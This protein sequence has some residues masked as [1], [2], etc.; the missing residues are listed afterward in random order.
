MLLEPGSEVPIAVVMV[1]LVGL[2][3]AALNL[4]VELEEWLVTVM[5]EVRSRLE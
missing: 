2:F 4:Q 3:K 5:R 1:G